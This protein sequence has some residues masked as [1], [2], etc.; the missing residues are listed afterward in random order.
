M[1]L[2][3]DDQIV[4]NVKYIIDKLHG[5][6]IGKAEG[7]ILAGI[8]QNFVEWCEQKERQE[9][10]V[11]THFRCRCGSCGAVHQVAKWLPLGTPI[12]C[13]PCGAQIGEIQP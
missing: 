12:V 5:D 3:A 13:I 8:F 11:K 4:N 10:A 9:I 1:E 6:E 7:K 2:L